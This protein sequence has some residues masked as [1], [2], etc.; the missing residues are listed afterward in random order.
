M[1]PRKRRSQ[2]T[3]TIGIAGSGAMNAKDLKANLTDYFDAVDD[4]LV[5]NFVVLYTDTPAQKAI[6][7]MISVFEAPIQC[8]M[9]EEDDLS[10]EKFAKHAK[11]VMVKR[12]GD[13]FG[14]LMAEYAAVGDA[15]CLVLWKDNDADLDRAVAIVNES[16]IP[17]LS[18]AN[19]MEAID[20]TLAE[21]EEAE[22][23]ASVAAETPAEAEEEGME[24]EEASALA[25]LTW[26]REFFSDYDPDGLRAVKKMLGLGTRGRFNHDIAVDQILAAAKAQGYEVT[27]EAPVE[28]Q[29]PQPQPQPKEE[30]E[31]K[32]ARTKP[33]VVPETAPVTAAAPGGNGQAATVD[34]RPL[35]TIKFEGPQEVATQMVR[36]AIARLSTEEIRTLLEEALA[37]Q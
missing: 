14:R 5:V 12:T 18:I 19:G 26:T 17:M 3:L 16:Q 9:R 2:A 30:P 10:E 36:D 29:A 4:S 32:K 37:S 11:A 31:P 27:D 24:P 6:R 7:Q 23:E 33:R 20:L 28:A 25:G 35:V 22:E 21:D 15:V 8:V 13:K 34:G 1:P